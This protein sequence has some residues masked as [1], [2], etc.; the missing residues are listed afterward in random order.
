MKIEIL[1]PEICNLYG[2][3]SNIEYLAKSCQDI[4]IVRTPITGNPYFAK[5]RPS[6]LYI[7]SMTEEAQEL[8]LK[9]LLPLKERL[10][11]LIEDE[12]P[13]LVTGNA[14]ELLGKAILPEEGKRI[15]CLDLYHT[16]ARRRMMQRHNSFYL[17][18]FKDENA[19]EMDIVGFKSQFAHSARESESPYPTDEPGIPL[20]QTV[21]GVGFDGG[22]GAEGIRF[23]NLIATYLIGPLLILNP[24]FAKYILRLTGA[25]SD[26]LAFE[27]TA[28]DV[29]A[30]R[31][32]EFSETSRPFLYG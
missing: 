27:K 25:P 18:K 29:Y 28:M 12:M 26:A 21:R 4:E 5:E 8:S 1:F 20:F 3:L 13:F 10:F 17:G 2:E 24:P 15:P 19:K 11:S 22:S 30:T 23:H 32:R 9:K 6:L 7:G 16:V 14:V 31:V